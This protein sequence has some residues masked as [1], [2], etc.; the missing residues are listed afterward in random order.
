MEDGILQ[1]WIIPVI[2]G[3]IVGWLSKSLWLILSGLILQLIEL[4]PLSGH[5]VPAIK[6]SWRNEFKEPDESGNIVISY[7]HLQLKQLGRLV[8][9]VG[10][11]ADGKGGPFHYHGK[12]VRNT[13]I[14]KYSVPK[15]KT[16]VGLGAFELT[17]KSNEKEMTGHC[18]WHDTDSD[19]IESSAFTMIKTS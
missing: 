1:T 13:L 19:K 8:W 7:E 17:V 10:K 4:V 3:V 15:R 16:P 2:I 6:G 5:F 11:R 14:G 12:L 9:G 18:V